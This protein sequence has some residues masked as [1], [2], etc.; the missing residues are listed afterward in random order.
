MSKQTPTNS[1]SKKISAFKNAT[2]VFVILFIAWGL[3][4]YLIQLP[5]EVEEFIVKPL[6]WLG[7]VYYFVRKEKARLASIGVTTKNLFPAVYFALGLGIVFALEG[8]LVNLIKYGTL[9]FNANIGTNNLLLSLVLSFA[10]AIS[11]ETAF[12]GYIFTRL[13][14]SFK[15]EWTANIITSIAWT[16]IHIPVTIFVLK[17][18]L[19]QT[20][21]YLFLTF[22]F[23]I[24]SAFVYARTKNIVS[25]IFLHVL[26]EWP[27]ILFR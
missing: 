18:D 23:G 8:L 26:W 17:Y 10:T 9:N 11:E 5:Q 4:R 12:R 27:I 7:I 1:I 22:I 3:Y 2:I 15:S 6:I 20:F 24:G 16:T 13:W 19:N 21:V 14:T 25:S